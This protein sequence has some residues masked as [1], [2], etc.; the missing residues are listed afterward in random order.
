MTD[1]LH[2]GGYGFYVWSAYGGAL[3]TVLAETF[4]VRRR[5][6]AA[7]ATARVVARSGVTKGNSQ[8]NRGTV[9]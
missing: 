3:L 4:A 5:L 9:V 1:F 2:M 7:R 8:R 6:R